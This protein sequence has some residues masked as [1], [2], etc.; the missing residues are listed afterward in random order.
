MTLSFCVCLFWLRLRCIDYAML[1]GVGVWQ[2]HDKRTLAIRP[3]LRLPSFQ[4]F[5]L[6]CVAMVCVCEWAFPSSAPRW[7]ETFE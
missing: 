6:G 3:P 7:E 5:V 2:V 4:S 1:L